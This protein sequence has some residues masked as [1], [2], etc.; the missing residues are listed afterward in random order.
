MERPENYQQSASARLRGVF[1]QDQRPTQAFDPRPDM[2][3]CTKKAS[4]RAQMTRV[5]HHPQRNGGGRS[6]QF[7]IHAFAKP[8]TVFRRFG[9]H[10]NR[11]I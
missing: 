8:R 10:R 3:L 2:P 7:A 1:Q 11:I 4:L 5:F 6:G 9:R